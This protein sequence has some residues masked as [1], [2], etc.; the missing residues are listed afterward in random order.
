MRDRVATI[1]TAA[2]AAFHLA[3]ANRYDVFR[4][5]L[6]FIVCGRHPAFG[7]A[8]QPPL[9]PLLAA[10]FY[11]ISAQAWVLRLPAV[12]AAAALV[13]LTIA[14]ARLLGGENG[15]AWIAGLAAAIAP[16]FIGITATLNTG[17]FEPLFW[18]LVAYLLTRC[19]VLDDRRALLWAGLAAGIALE[20]KYALP[21]WLG[22]LALGL[23]CFPERRI[24]ARRELWLGVVIATLLALPSLIWQSLNGWPFVE[25]VHN[26]GYKDAAVAPLAFAVQ[27]VFALNPLLAPVWIGGAIAPFTMRALR[28]V[29]FLSIAFLITAIAIVAGHGKDYYLAPAYPSLFA[30]GAVAW[31]RI[32][33]SSAARTAYLALAT[34]FSVVIAPLTIPI[35]APAS[36]IAYVRALHLAPQQQES[37]D[38]GDLIPSWMADMLGWHDFV[39]EVGT[40][41]ASL[42][43]G[44][45][46]ATAVL[47]TN[48]GDAAAL[49]IYGGEYG[50]PPAL[51]G[52]NQYYYWGLRGQNP[53]DVL[54]VDSDT[55]GL[56]AHCAQV[57]TFGTTA[58]PYARSF[59]N[60]QTISLCRGVHP[61]L[62]KLWPAEKKLI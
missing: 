25:L 50:L 51:S 38:R 55:S 42:S 29:R 36:L 3:F 21:L 34:A 48:Y 39:R 2:T 44:E 52:H 19:V 60:G 11:G 5:E 4:D 47:V 14:F 13:W 12:F 1:L 32:V 18:T 33:R 22:A 20:M 15:A 24:L 49:D 10:A 23:L 54:D 45:R 16:I 6:Y 28:N 56:A 37:A 8:D 35:L 57:K 31:E 9:V 59:E 17:T 62:E 46:A 40:A 53:Q 58:S 27:Q 41:Y 61:S 7:Y 43:P 30:V 26:A